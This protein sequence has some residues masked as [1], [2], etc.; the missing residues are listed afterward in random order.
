MTRADS[1][2]RPRI[3]D[4]IDQMGNA[5]YMSTFD[6]LKGYWQIPLTDRA[7]RISTFIV[8][9][10]TYSYITMPFGMRN[11]PATFQRYMNTVIRGLKRTKVYTDD[12]IIYSDTWEEHLSAINALFE[13]LSEYNLTV[14][15]NK[16]VFCQGTVKFLGH[17]IGQGHVAPLASKIETICNYSIPQNKKSLMR[18]LGMAGF[19]RRFCPN[20]SHLVS[21][22]TNLLGNKVRYVWSGEC[23]KA[24]EAVKTVLINIW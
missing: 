19:Y 14:N 23:R 6:L 24:F 17:T 22:L 4:C 10:G 2:P 18:F 7:K 13:R 11:A 20:F 8:P 5:K 15:L 9:D 1:F 3:D 12:L 21:S 16:S